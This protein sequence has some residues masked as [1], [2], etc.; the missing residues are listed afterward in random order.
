MAALHHHSSAA[1][2][3]SRRVSGTGEQSVPISSPRMLSRPGSA[4]QMQEN[5]STGAGSLKVPV[6]EHLSRTCCL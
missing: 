4:S 2:S 3:D 5:G 1:S 6:Q